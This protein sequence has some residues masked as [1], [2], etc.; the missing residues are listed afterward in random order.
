ML[1]VP[2]KSSLYRCGSGPA[3]VFDERSAWIFVPGDP[4]TPEIPANPGDEEIRKTRYFALIR[5]KDVHRAS[6]TAGTSWRWRVAVQWQPSQPA[7]RQVVLPNSDSDTSSIS[8]TVYLFERVAHDESNGAVIP[9]GL[10]RIPYRSPDV[11]SVIT[12][13]Q[14]Y[15]TTNP[16]AASAV[17]STVGFKTL[18][19]IPQLTGREA[20]VFENVNSL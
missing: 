20:G 12:S 6:R 8:C 16:N 5:T 19:G 4:D 18:G 3:Q 14:V 11:I 7:V 2:F 13:S 10:W 17:R 1:L 9:L 15:F